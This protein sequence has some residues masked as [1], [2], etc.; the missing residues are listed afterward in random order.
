M[1]LQDLKTQL[2]NAVA[3]HNKTEAELKRLAKS[4]ATALTTSETHKNE[5][6]RLASLIEVQKTKH[7]ADMAQMRKTT[8][9]LQRDKSDLQTLVE[10]A[11]K[12]A[13][14]AAVATPGST[15]KTPG[16]RRFGTALATPGRRWGEGRGG[17]DEGEVDEFGLGG[18]GGG[19]TRRRGPGYDLG[20]QI[21]SPGFGR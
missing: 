12:A 13:S 10:K 5:T 2:V 18:G 1:H 16:E 6:D 14:R 11:Q 4:H 19:S 8:A 17:G 7:E 3:S 21:L 15:R 9:G 20:G